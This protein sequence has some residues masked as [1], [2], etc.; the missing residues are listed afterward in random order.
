MF[1][2][3][4]HSDPEASAELWWVRSHLTWEQPIRGAGAGATGGAA[5]GGAG[6]G[7]GGGARGEAQVG[8]EA[9]ECLWRVHLQKVQSRWESSPTNFFSSM[10]LKH[11][12]LNCKSKKQV[13]GFP[14]LLHRSSTTMGGRLSKA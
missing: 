13:D 1:L 6:G 11:L 2:P 12:Q 14:L 8:P 10:S 9:E 4:S 7:G 5:A 3:G